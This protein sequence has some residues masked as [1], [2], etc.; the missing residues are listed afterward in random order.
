M[1]GMIRYSATMATIDQTD[2]TIAL[3]AGGVV[4]AV[5]VSQM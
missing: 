3:A 5:R 2:C 1:M 4:G